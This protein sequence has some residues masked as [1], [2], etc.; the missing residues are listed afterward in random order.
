MATCRAHGAHLFELG[1]ID[2]EDRDPAFGHDLGEE[3]QLGREIGIRRAMII[4]MVVTDV[5]EGRRRNA[6]AVEPVLVEPVAGGL[7]GEMLNALA[8]KPVQGLMQRHRIGC[9]ECCAGATTCGAQAQRPEAAAVDADA[10]PNLRRE[11]GRRGFAVRAGDR[12]DGFGLMG[13]ETRRHQRKPATRIVVGYD[14]DIVAFYRYV[15][16]RE[17][18]DG[19]LLDRIGDEARAVGA[20]AAQGG[21]HVTR[22]HRTA[23][24]GDAG[25]FD[26][27]GTVV[28][29]GEFGKTHHRPL[30]T[31]TRMESVVAGS[32]TA[33]AMPSNG[34]MRPTMRLVVGAAVQPALAKLKVRSV[35]LGS[36]RAT[37][38]T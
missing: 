2:V 35:P 23:V 28:R 5:G 33:G 27:R 29:A 38:T 26:A 8:R 6:H 3:A 14:K 20:H 12:D 31:E 9:S 25:D 21:K 16:R 13:V 11:I 19:A 10:G 24:G 22:H 7:H 4:E 18:R 34:A 32:L 30:R 15:R 36:S 1:N 17:D 37:K